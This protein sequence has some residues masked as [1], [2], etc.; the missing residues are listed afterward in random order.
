MT[1]AVTSPNGKVVLA[2]VYPA[3]SPQARQTV[4][5]VN[6]LRHNLIPRPSTA[7]AWSSTSAG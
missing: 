5:L 1:P 6:D 3:T 7:P 4:N 2:T